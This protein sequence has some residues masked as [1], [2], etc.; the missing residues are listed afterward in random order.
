MRR[1]QEDF[2][3]KIKVGHTCVVCPLYKTSS[4]FLILTPALTPIRDFAPDS[5]SC[6]FQIAEPGTSSSSS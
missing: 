3:E 5:G 6:Q 1:L 4:Y 2:D